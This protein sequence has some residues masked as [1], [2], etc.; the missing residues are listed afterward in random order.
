MLAALGE[1]VLG[2]LRDAEPFQVHGEEGGV[3]QA[4]DVAEMAVGLGRHTW[5]PSRR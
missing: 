2:V 3:V 1:E 5:A 4:V